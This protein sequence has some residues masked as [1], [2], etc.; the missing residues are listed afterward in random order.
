MELEIFQA[1]LGE[2]ATIERIEHILMG[3]RRCVYR[4]N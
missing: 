4:V 1:A 3:D 2:D